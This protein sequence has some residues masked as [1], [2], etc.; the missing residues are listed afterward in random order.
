MRKISFNDIYTESHLVVGTELYSHYHNPEMLIQYDS[1]YLQFH[2][3]PTL[4]EF[5]EAATYLKEFHQKNGQKHVKFYFPENRK[6]SEELIQFFH[7]QSFEYGY[8]ELYAIQPEQFP[9]T[10]NHPDIT[11]RIVSE[12]NFDDYLQVQYEQDLE[13]GEE[14]AKAKPALYRRHFQ[15][16][17]F[18]QIMSYYQGT[19]VGSLEVIIKEDT[20]EIDGLHVHQ[21]FRKKGI[22]QR[23]QKFV[24]DQFPNKTIILVADGEDTPR[25]MYIRQ[26]YRYLGFQYEVQKVDLKKD[27]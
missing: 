27:E 3:M 20:A 9:I 2:R 18:M 22:A 15:D 13:F 12:V 4:Q 8:L 24:M 23:L 5:I 11:I 10:D 21:A 19:A 6:P 1:N 25:E 26:N 17:T 7:H 16:E 14:F